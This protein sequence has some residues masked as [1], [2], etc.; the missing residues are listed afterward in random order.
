MSQILPNQIYEIPTVMI[1]KSHKYRILA[2]YPDRG[3]V[4]LFP[5]DDESKLKRPTLK[6]I[7]QIERLIKQT[8][9][10]EEL[11]PINF[12][13]ASDDAISESHKRKRDKNYH[14]IKGLVEGEYEETVFQL[15]ASKKSLL[16]KEYAAKHNFELTSV[17]RAI[18]RFWYYGQTKNALLPHYFKSGNLGREMP[19]S[20]KKRGRPIASYSGLI[21][22]EQGRS[23]TEKDKE[24][25]KQYIKQYV[26]IPHP[27]PIAKVYRLMIDL[28][29]SYSSEAIIAEKNGKK[30][31][32]PT[33]VQFRYWEKKLNSINDKLNTQGP[34]YKRKQDNRDSLKGVNAMSSLPGDSFQIDA[35]VAD[36][37]VV[38]KYDR[39]IVLGRPTIYSITDTATRMIV[40]LHV[41]LGHP[42]WESARQT[43]YNT[44]TP[45]GDYCSRLGL[46]IEDEEW[47][48]YHAPR[49]LICDRGEMIGL[50]P[51][52]NLPLC[53]LRYT[54][55]GRPEMKGVV[56]R[57]FRIYNDE[58]LHNMDGTTR[59]KGYS[60]MDAKP[61]TTA[62]YT[63]DE[64]A[65][66]L[67][68]EAIKQNN[69]K[70]NDVK[71]LKLVIQSGIYP[72]AI[73]AW[74]LYL[75]HHRHSLKIYS[76]QQVFA[77]LLQPT[78][79]SVTEY[80]FEY[81]DLY[82][83]CTE[84]Q[85][86]NL[87]T[88]SKKFGEYQLEARIN[89]DDTSYIFV[90][91]NKVSPFIKCH[92]TPRST[93]LANLHFYDFNY[94]R[95][96]RKL[97]GQN[98]GASAV[99]S[100]MTKEQD[101]LKREAKANKSNSGIKNKVT[102]IKENRKKAVKNEESIFKPAVE[103]LPVTQRDLQASSLPNQYNI[104][105]LLKV[106]PSRRKRNEE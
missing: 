25:F 82:Y 11:T 44:F 8:K 100:K 53:S 13:T 67:A 52:H 103:K 86:E 21:S 69:K 48:C 38:Y 10:L 3:L 12:L 28:E 81:S 68:A 41:T 66:T 58:Q 40:G 57:V 75:S 94:L 63:L 22:F 24:I 59:G 42:S 39:S 92:L 30:A 18:N 93:N 20:N 76:P 104:V 29:E 16:L 50:K 89:R 97:H 19:D 73:N 98:D 101:Q 14:L 9:E 23:I 7:A 37:Y 32:N 36:V 65:K 87:F 105:D 77:N 4:A 96:L 102:K 26:N 1:A 49:E 61:A 43:I 106:K 17:Y 34:A 99:R 79:V 71:N 95:D 33:L 78:K 88:L 56:E 64:V 70:N 5:L 45:K 6:K 74:K 54:P 90:K 80:G 35:T 15:A 83:T 27:L 84:A 85:N 55:S 51:E 47:P 72:S 31:N 62:T 2:V 60:R 46:E 91:L